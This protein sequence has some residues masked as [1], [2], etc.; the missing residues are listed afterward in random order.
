LIEA[1]KTAV[2]C[3]SI[4]DDAGLTVIVPRTGA[5]SVIEAVAGVEL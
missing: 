5:T 2:N 4:D 3:R 1:V